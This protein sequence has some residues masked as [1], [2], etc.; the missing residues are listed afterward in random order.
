M[1]VKYIIVSLSQSFQLPL[2]IKRQTGSPGGLSYVGS[3]LWALLVGF[4]AIGQHCVVWGLRIWKQGGCVDGRISYGEH[5][6]PGRISPAGPTNAQVIDG[7][8]WGHRAIE[9][10]SCGYE[11]W[12]RSIPSRRGTQCTQRSQRLGP[13]GGNTRWN[14]HCVGHGRRMW[15]HEGR[16][17]C[18]AEGGRMCLRDL[19]SVRAG[20][21][22][23]CGG[24]S[25]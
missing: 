4:P 6:L 10:S 17:V 21:C 5:S 25:R 11:G 22:V 1:L 15:L 7:H 24:G 9:A 19:R 14:A 12:A 18:L 8:Q 23:M 3:P 20:H 16:R 2:Y 13:N